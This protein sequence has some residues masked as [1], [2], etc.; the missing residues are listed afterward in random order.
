MRIAF[1]NPMPLGPE[2]QRLEHLKFRHEEKWAASRALEESVQ[3]EMD[4][5]RQID[6]TLPHDCEYRGKSLAEL[7]EVVIERP[8]G[9]PRPGRNTVG[10]MDAD[11]RLRGARLV[12]IHRE[13]AA[14][15]RARQHA[16]SRES[17]AMWQLIEACEKYLNERGIQ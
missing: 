12:A 7:A 6:V 8:E 10:R 4:C 17:A 15:L 14:T 3:Y 1:N 13:R 11:A 9:V 16:V 5:A 2:R